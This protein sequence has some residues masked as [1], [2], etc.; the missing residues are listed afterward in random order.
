MRIRHISETER[1]ELQIVPMID[2][3]FQLLV[4]FIM[5]FKI[6]A[7]EGDFN[8]KMPRAAVDQQVPDSDQLPPMVLRLSAD[9]AGQLASIRLNERPLSSFQELQQYL[10]GLLEGGPEEGMGEAEIELDCDYQLKYDY[11]VAAITAVTGY[12]S[13]EGQIVRLIEQ[14]KFAPPNKPA[15]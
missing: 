9:S 15:P 13:R 12:I 10:I 8:I 1:I 7:L 4:F 5:S 11:V 14:I 3:V 2:I 6:S